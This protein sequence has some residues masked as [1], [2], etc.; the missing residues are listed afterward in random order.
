MDDQKQ[1]TLEEL[2]EEL[3]E[4]QKIFA[5]NYIIDW[6]ATRSYKK[7]YGEM[8]DNVA[9]VCGCKLLRIANV[10][11]YINFIKNN[12]EEEAGVSKLRVL[13]EF[14]KIAFS[15]IAHLHNTWIDR[16]EFESLTDDQKASIES[17]DTKT[18]TINFNE[19]TKEV[20]YVKIKLYSK[21]QA[22]IEIKKMLGYD[23][24]VKS[25]IT[26]GGEKITQIIKWGDKEII[27]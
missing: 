3:N 23:L 21:L 5:H 11:Q 20:E 16:K 2:K 17:I 24:P 12:L 9:A 1:Y 13:N 26:S 15:S 10:K 25:D 7:A 4:K 19:E 14:T 6:N 18:V 27:L 22:N 8:D